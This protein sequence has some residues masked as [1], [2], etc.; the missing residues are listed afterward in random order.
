[1]IAPIKDGVKHLFPGYF[2]LVMATD[3]F[4]CRLSARNEGH[5][6]RLFRLNAVAY[7]IL[8]VLTVARF[9]LPALPWL[10]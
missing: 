6:L 3:R 2:A 4:D 7:V 1:M 8:W 10:T 5:R 9:M